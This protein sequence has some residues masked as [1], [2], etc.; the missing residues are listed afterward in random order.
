M[1][2]VGAEPFQNFYNAAASESITPLQASRYF[3]AKHRSVKLE[4][5]KAGGIK[6]TKSTDDAFIDDAV[7]AVIDKVLYDRS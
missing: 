1:S 2:F 7:Y 5:V 3:G 6:H 4:F